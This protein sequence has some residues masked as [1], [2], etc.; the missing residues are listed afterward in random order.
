MSHVANVVDYGADPLGEVDS[1]TAF[2]AAQQASNDIFVP[3]GLYLKEA[4]TKIVS[5]KTWTFDGAT[6][7]HSRDTATM[8]SAE[9]AKDWNILGHL[10]LYGL[11]TTSADTGECGFR[12]KNP[13]RAYIERITVDRFKGTG[14]VVDGML[15]QTRG[16]KLTIGSIAAYSNYQGFDF[17][18]ESGAEYL[19]IDSIDAVQ[20]IYA[21]TIS[22]GNCQIRGGNIT[23]NYYGLLLGSGLNHGHGGLH[24]MNLNHNVY[25]N[26]KAENVEAGFTLNGCH[27]FAD[28]AS[29][30]KIILQDSKGVSI[31][32][33]IVEAAIENSGRVGK[34]M[35][36]DNYISGDGVTR[37]GGIDPDSLIRIG[38]YDSQGMWG[39]N[40]R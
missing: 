2:E 16:D 5:G 23:D 29:T 19:S 39:L 3:N 15:Y 26:L 33:G 1:S 14:I 32:D 20:N 34:N 11:L 17:R 22:A 13:K 21:G 18:P 10:R 28:D 12:I 7:I 4:E 40:N 35:L 25:W 37:V 31:R 6:I 24:G 38:N 36:Q 8:F 9:D 27:V 30:G